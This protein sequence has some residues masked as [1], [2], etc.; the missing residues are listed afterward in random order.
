MSDEGKDL[1]YSFRDAEADK[2][3]DAT[4]ALSS[5]SWTEENQQDGGATYETHP[6]SVT[7]YNTGKKL[8]V[9]LA[10]T[11]THVANTSDTIPSNAL[12][13][14]EVGVD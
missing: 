8:Y 11:S 10:E 13:T 3:G 9:G 5:L 7:V 6:V 4:H 1:S 14:I 2:D 12:H